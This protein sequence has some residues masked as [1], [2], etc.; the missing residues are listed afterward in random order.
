MAGRPGCVVREKQAMVGEESRTLVER[1]RKVKFFANGREDGSRQGAWETS[2]GQSE[3]RT[4]L[5]QSKMTPAAP[6]PHH[7]RFQHEKEPLHLERTGHRVSTAIRQFEFDMFLEDPVIVN[8][9]MSKFCR[10]LVRA[11]R[12][13]VKAKEQIGS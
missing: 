8:S 1:I 12:I 10:R 7:A 2:G 6:F 5:K 3:T 9:E 4:N 13:D 11:A